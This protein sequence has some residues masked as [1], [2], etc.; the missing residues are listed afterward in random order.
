MT[1]NIIKTDNY[2]LVVD[3][4][5]TIGK[6]YA[7][8]T[9]YKLLLKYDT[10]QHL[11]YD[12]D[13]VKK[14]IAHVPLNG[15]PVLEG[16]DLL[17]PFENAVQ[18]TDLI[19]SMACRYRHDFF[20]LSENEKNAI[21]ITMNQILEE[22]IGIG[23]YKGK[24]Y[25]YTEEDMRKAWDAGQRDALSIDEETYKPFFF[26]ELIKSF[27]PKEFECEMQEY[28]RD[29]P[30]IHSKYYLPKTITNS[31]GQRVWVG[32]YKQPRN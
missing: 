14:I 12:N 18:N 15:S 6:G 20:L 17:P 27:Y 11:A 21:R 16:V 28:V 5:R 29:M 23:F 25:K 8:N 19:D 4:S 1:H 22:V 7:L 26:D 31:Q 10:D 24:T 13:V 32:K 2:L 9:S 3:D 30:N